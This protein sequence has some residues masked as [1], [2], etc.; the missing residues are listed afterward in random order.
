MRENDI[1]LEKKIVVVLFVVEYF[2]IVFLIAIQLCLL[3]LQVHI[4]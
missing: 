4:L 3:K 2:G 1:F